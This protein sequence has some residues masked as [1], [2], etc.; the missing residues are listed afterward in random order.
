MHARSITVPWQIHADAVE[1]I[2]ACY[3]TPQR[4]DVA[5][6]AHETVDEYDAGPSSSRGE[7]RDAKHREGRFE[8][9]I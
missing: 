4:L 6:I 5:P 7:R 8:L 2:E 9:E 3:S 1:A